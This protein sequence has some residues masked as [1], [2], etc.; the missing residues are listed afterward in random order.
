VADAL[1]DVAY[2]FHLATS[3]R[4]ARSSDDDHRRV[5]VTSTRLLAERAAALP[6]FGRFVHV[7]TVGV[8]GHIDGVPADENYPFRPG[9]S[10]QQTKAEAEQW[11]RDFAPANGLSSTVIR[12]AGIFGPG[13]R[14]LLKLFKMASRRFFFL[15]GTG[16]C[17]YHLIHVDDLTD[18]LILA[19]T[20]P[21]AEGE[22]F[23]CGNDGPISL[24]EIGRIVAGAM[25]RRIRVVRLPAGPFF[26]AAALCEKICRPLGIEPPIY[27]RRVAFFTKDRMFDTRKLRDVLGY[28]TAY[29]NEQ[30]L[31]QTTQWYI[32][33]GWL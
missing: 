2:V 12:P 9:D 33:N 27:R 10:Y 30:G 6:G 22:V 24:P 11:L 15:L 19:A 17:F 14:R 28:R 32:E 4:E 20:H 1:E 18:V 13:D 16:H 5:H 26:A 25:G 31:I 21:K 3:Y 29:T 7:S 23:I 8:H